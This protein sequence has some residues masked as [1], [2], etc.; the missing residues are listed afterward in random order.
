MDEAGSFEDNSNPNLRKEL[1]EQVLDKE[2]ISPVSS[3]KGDT[4]TGIEDD[5]ELDPELKQPT[6]KTIS[7]AE[8]LAE[9]LED[10]AQFH[11]HK[12][13]S[14]VLKNLLVMQ[15]LGV[16]NGKCETLRDHETSVFLC[17]PETIWL[18]RLRDQDFKVFWV[19]ARDVQPD[20]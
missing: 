12:K 19:R 3:N 10:F 4:E 17:E 5:D 1:W 14:L 13:L 6:I 11:G 7:N 16:A 20:S 15:I 18:F 2:D 8:E 9:Q